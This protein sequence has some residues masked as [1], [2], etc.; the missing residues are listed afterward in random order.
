GV[1]TTTQVFTPTLNFS[2]GGPVWIRLILRGTASGTLSGGQVKV[3]VYA[4]SGWTTD[5]YAVTWSSTPPAGPTVTLPYSSNLFSGADGVSYVH[6][7][8]ALGS[9]GTTQSLALVYNSTAARPVV[10]VFLDAIGTT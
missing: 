3:Q 5:P 2:G 9:M 6:A 10:L 8:P 1:T 4:S 7:T